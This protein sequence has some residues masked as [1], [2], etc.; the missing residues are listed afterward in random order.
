MGNMDKNA[1]A[2]I[3]KHVRIYMYVCMYNVMTHVSK[4]KIELTYNGAYISH[5]FKNTLIFLPL[6]CVK[7]SS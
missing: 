3:Q 6:S 1:P 5:V 4:H 7:F 2:H